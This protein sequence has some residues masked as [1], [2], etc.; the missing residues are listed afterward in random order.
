MPEIL[1][2]FAILMRRDIDFNTLSLGGVAYGSDV[3]EFPFER[4]SEITLAKVVERASYSD[5]VGYRYY[6]EN[7]K[8]LK[9]SEVINS[10]IEDGGVFH[11]AEKVSFF[12]NNG[13]V[14]GFSIYGGHERFF[15]YLPNF[16]IFIQEF[17][18]PDELKTSMAHG[19]EFMKKCLYR[20]CKK[21]VVWNTVSQ[22]IVCFVL[23][24]VADTL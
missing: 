23:G 8:E 20:G 24:D 19:D 10:V 16:E 14:N 7:D 1:E 4:I 2:N 21:L 3:R 9:K 5:D 12:V 17:G 15:R 6:D 13:R 11:F 18:N 22:E